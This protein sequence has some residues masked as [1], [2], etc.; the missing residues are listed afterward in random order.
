MVGW[1]EQTAGQ[2]GQGEERLSHCP[3]FLEISCNM[4]SW[5]TPCPKQPLHGH[6]ALD[7][8]RTWTLLPKVCLTSRVVFYLPRL[9]LSPGQRI[10]R[11]YI[12]GRVQRRLDT[13]FYSPPLNFLSI[14][15]LSSFQYYNFISYQVAK[16]KTIFFDTIIIL[17]LPIEF[18]LLKHVVGLIFALLNASSF[19]LTADFLKEQNWDSAN[20]WLCGEVGLWCRGGEW[21]LQVP[22]GQRWAEGGLR[23]LLFQDVG[24][25]WLTNLP[26]TLGQGTNFASALW[27]FSPLKIFISLFLPLLGRPSE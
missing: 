12:L 2:L 1:V 21:Q 9:T 5:T 15:P 13:V 16:D 7:F 11:A 6:L 26:K 8:P 27:E 19:S 14:T 25:Q 10:L 23:L 20:P 18:T 17:G 3:V 24:G 22:G 4:T